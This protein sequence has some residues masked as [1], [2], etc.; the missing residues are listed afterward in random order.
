MYGYFRYANPLDSCPLL[1]LRH[2]PRALSHFYFS[3]A[4]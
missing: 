2:E 3:V 1:A 4:N